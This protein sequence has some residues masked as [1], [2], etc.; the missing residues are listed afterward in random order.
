MTTSESVDRTVRQIDD[1]T[2]THFFRSPDDGPDRQ[3]TSS[4]QRQDP[5]VSRAKARQRTAAW[6]LRLDRQRRPEARDIGMAMVSA[7]VMSPS[8]N[9]QNPDVGE[10]RLVRAALADLERRGYDISEVLDVLVK[11]RRRLRGGDRAPQEESGSVGE[12]LHSHAG[13]RRN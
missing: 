13:D 8:V 12:T 3:F 9:L 2:R 4:R 11:L 1:D 5:T 6:R 10:I 7:L